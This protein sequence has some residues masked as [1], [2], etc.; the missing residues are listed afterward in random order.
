MIASAR[1]RARRALLR[2][3]LTQA[4]V[5]EARRLLQNERRQA[6]M[7]RELLAECRARLDEVLAA[8]GPDSALVLELTVEER[9]L[10]ARESSTQARLEL[11]MA[12]FLRPEQAT[13]LRGLAPDAVGDL[14]VRL[15][16]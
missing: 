7:A 10:V 8:P 13:R 3:S 15:G 6:E 12:A 2:L 9:L 16:G 1:Q 11:S 5:E 4:Q 14:L